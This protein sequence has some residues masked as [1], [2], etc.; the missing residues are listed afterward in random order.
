MMNDINIILKNTD[1]TT[2]K[3]DLI[4]LKYTADNYGL[5]EEI[6]L[7]LDK[8]KIENIS[9]YETC[10]YYK[11]KNLDSEEVLFIRLPATTKL[12]YNN[13]TTFSEIMISHIEK[14]DV[15]NCGMT[16]NGADF[17]DEREAFVSQLQGIINMI[18]KSQIP[19][20]LDSI[21]IAEN[22][23]STFSRL[24]KYLND[25]IVN[26]NGYLKKKAE[27]TYSLSRQIQ[28]DFKIVNNHKE[29][30]FVAMPFSTEFEDVFYYGIQNAIEANGFTSLRIDKE[31]FMGDIV[32]EM[33]E[34]IKSSKA[35]IA[36]L[37]N[38]NA[39]VYLE[40]GFAWGKDI[41]ALLITQNIDELKFDVK[42]RRCIKY[43]TIRDLEEQLTE[44]IK[45][46]VK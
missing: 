28:H 13:I 5:S 12:H 41:K 37:T 8:E 19:D 32:A 40:L 34:K 46:L 27:N 43:N 9:I 4:T 21:I 44:E 1:I 33:F 22:D 20:F 23:K 15:K 38:S 10:S 17:L 16:L 35:V 24:N 29:H 39:N 6:L 30:I 14:R 36:D 2:L 42:G 26:S 18:K 31:K 3:V 45:S 25:L 11:P 7:R